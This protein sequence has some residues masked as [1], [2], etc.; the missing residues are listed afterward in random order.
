MYPFCTFLTVRLPF[1]I[2]NIDLYS[3]SQVFRVPVREF[4][5]KFHNFVIKTLVVSD[6]CFNKIL[7]F[8]GPYNKI[9]KFGVKFVICDLE[10]LGKLKNTNKKVIFSNGHYND[11]VITK[12]S[13]FCSNS[14]TRTLITQKI[15][16]KSIKI[17]I[18]SDGCYNQ[19]R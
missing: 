12:L 1:L 11:V 7:N 16:K 15:E 14:L 4:E 19:V 2:I 18:F 8:D 17:V 13:N 6:P 9:L 5:L 10:N 3:F